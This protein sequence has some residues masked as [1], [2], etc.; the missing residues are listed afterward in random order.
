[1]NEVRYVGKLVK[2][3]PAVVFSLAWTTFHQSDVKCC[4]LTRLRE[5]L[6][7]D[8]YLRIRVI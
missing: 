5:L 1:M 6:N 3:N 4:E 2:C 8:V 7:Y